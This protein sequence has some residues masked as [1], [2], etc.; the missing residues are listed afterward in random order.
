M[1]S[2]SPVVLVRESQVLIPQF[3]YHTVFPE[4]P[5]GPEFVVFGIQEIFV[6]PGPYRPAGADNKSRCHEDITYAGFS[7]CL[8][9]GGS[10]PAV[11]FQQTTG[12]LSR[13]FINYR[14]LWPLS[15]P[16]VASG[17][18]EGLLKWQQAQPVPCPRTE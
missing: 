8:F 3:I 7:I 11:Y 6:L 1:A 14:T 16:P 18:S 17:Y 9:G 4:P 5:K 12:S 13:S 10:F 2:V 15:R